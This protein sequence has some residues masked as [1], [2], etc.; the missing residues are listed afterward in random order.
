VTHNVVTDLL[1]QYTGTA[2][3]RPFELKGDVL[4]IGDPKSYIRRFKRV[5]PA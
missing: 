3:P 1:R 5:A 2:Q 4:I